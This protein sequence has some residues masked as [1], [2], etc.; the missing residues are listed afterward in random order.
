MSVDDT[1]AKAQAST[2]SAM[3]KAGYIK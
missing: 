2:E 3:K 1:L